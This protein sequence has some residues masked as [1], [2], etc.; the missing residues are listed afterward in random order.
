[1][2]LFLDVSGIS[3]SCRKLIKHGPLMTQA[4]TPVQITTMLNGSN[5]GA[6]DMRKNDAEWMTIVRTAS[7]L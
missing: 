4:P 1:M 3:M 2:P 6:Q 5:T 7:I